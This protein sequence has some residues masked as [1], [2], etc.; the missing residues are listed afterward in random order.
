MQRS[1][2]RG[3]LYRN[4]APGDV[5]LLA[6][7]RLPQRVADDTQIGNLLP[8]PFGFGIETADALSRAGVFDILLMVPDAHSDIKFVVNDAGPAPHVAADAGI[9]PSSTFRAGDAFGVEIARDRARALSTRELAKDALDDKRLGRIDLAL[10][11]HQLAFARKPPHH[12]IA[13]AD[14]ARREAFLDPPAKAAMRLLGKVF[15]EQRVH[16]ALEPDVQLA[17]FAFGQRHER[18]A[19][20]LE[21]LEQC[22]DIGLI[23]RYPVERFSDHHIELP[24][25][26]IGEQRLDTRPQDHARPRDGSIRIAVRNHPAF[27]LRAFAADALLVGDR[28]RALLVGGIA[29]IERGAD[30]DIFLSMSRHQEAAQPDKTVSRGPTLASTL[31]GRRVF[32]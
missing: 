22:R 17:D 1:R 16:R 24:R 19:R 31:W 6:L 11:A 9:A 15:E 26:R 25:L 21:M 3:F 27:A 32:L 18:N 28:R 20:K 12:P 8:D 2:L 29:G 23:A 30:H 4:I 5:R 7:H 13:I 14:G 10:A